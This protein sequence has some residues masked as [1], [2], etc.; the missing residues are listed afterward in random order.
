MK[1]K[2]KRSTGTAVKYLLPNVN[3]WLEFNHALSIAECSVCTSF[4]SNAR[5]Y[6]NACPGPNECVTN[7][8]MNRETDR[9]S[10][11]VLQQDINQTSGTSETLDIE[12]NAGT[13]EK[14]DQ[15]ADYSDKRHSILR[16]ILE[17]DIY[18]TVDMTINT[19]YT[20]NVDSLATT[21]YRTCA[22]TIPLIPNR[23]IPH[24]T[25]TATSTI[26]TF[27]IEEQ[28][29]QHIIKKHTTEPLT[30]IEEKLTKSLFGRLLNISGMS[31][32]KSDILNQL[33]LH[34]Q[35]RPPTEQ[36]IKEEER[37]VTYIIKKKLASSHTNII[38]CKTGGPPLTLQRI[39]N[40]RKES[41]DI[42]TPTKRK[43]TATLQN[44][45]KRISGKSP[46]S[47]ESQQL[48]HLS[49]FSH[50]TRRDIYN[51]HKKYNRIK[52]F[53]DKALALKEALGMT[54][55]KWRINKRFLKTLGVDFEHEGSERKLMK[56]IT[57]D[58]VKVEMKVFEDAKG[59]RCKTAFGCI[60]NLSEFVCDLLTKYKEAGLLIS[61]NGIIPDNEIHLK[62]GGDFGK[63]S[64][65]I[66]MQIV[67]LEKPNSKDNTIVIAMANIKDKYRNLEKFINLIKS[68][69]ECL[70]NLIWNEKK[71]IVFLF[72][73]LAFLT[74]IFG[75]SGSAGSCPCLW[76]LET[77]GGIKNPSQNIQLRSLEMIK[78]DHQKFLL[79]GEG[80]PK[81]VKFYNN[82]L[83]EPLLDIQLEYVAP[84]YLHFLLG[85]V[86]K[87]H[88][89][90]EAEADKIDIK[91]MRT[92]DTNNQTIN[93]VR[94]YGEN[95]RN[96]EDLKHK[97]NSLVDKLISCTNQEVPRLTQKLKE[98]QIKLKKLGYEG[99]EARSGPVC[100]YLDT[101]LK[102]H[103][104]TPQPYHGR[105]FIGN[106]CDKYLTHTVY[107]DITNAL[108]GQTQALTTQQEII[109][110]AIAVRDQFNSLNA[111]YAI[112]HKS[113]SHSRPIDK[114]KIP[115]IQ[116]SITTYMNLFR[117]HFP[118]MP[119]P[120][121]HVLEFHC[122][123]WV[124]RHGAGMGVTW[125]TRRGTCPL[126]YI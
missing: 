119:I 76:C 73:D 71:V 62:L 47:V 107:T 32:C 75:L 33:L 60:R 100:S 54:W 2:L 104:I 111:A 6:I 55:T 112:V 30:P 43:R 95:W 48:H 36:T 31:Y 85:I 52:I 22:S 117:E 12:Q 27:D 88:Q 90:L 4:C 89:L 113:I 23:P 17:R 121:Q 66:S 46:K 105:S 5:L 80:N 98:E 42:R 74:S 126:D 91:I 41:S 28:A 8:D 72:G 16:D 25:D 61:H 57:S 106:H 67:N 97:I 1:T 9:V 82:C 11:T 78:S 84:P 87:H 38:Q 26:P 3:I 35:N 53:K 59:L 86:L 45:L 64:F 114:D 39:P 124:R 63:Q 13:S 77:Q 56:E 10:D 115:S 125:G 21:D 92:T 122:T 58:F 7:T 20:V 102:K 118:T 34:L 37:Y 94:E 51:I 29:L 14:Q 110:I 15:P 99:L 50:T 123:N 70:Q 79:H 24:F 68:Q 93:L 65:K 120:K 18:P 116:H 101:I 103:R 96:A 109:D 81:K 83:H 108:V 49:R 69:V 44:T 40:P 19:T